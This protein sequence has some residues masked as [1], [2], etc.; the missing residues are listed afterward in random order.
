MT[1]K[2][3]SPSGVIRRNERLCRPTRLNRQ[4]EK[5]I[6][7]NDE[8]LSQGVE[9]SQKGGEAGGPGDERPPSGWCEPFVSRAPSPE[10]REKEFHPVRWARESDA[11]KGCTNLFD[12]RP[13]FASSPSRIGTSTPP[14]P[15]PSKKKP[16]RVQSQHG[17][18]YKL[19]AKR[20]GTL[21]K[22]PYTLHGRLSRQ[23][24]IKKK[25][26]PNPT[27]QK[28]HHPSQ[29]QQF[30]KNKRNQ[31]IV[32]ED[33]YKFSESPKETPAQQKRELEKEAVQKKPK[34]NGKIE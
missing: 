12:S 26:N 34:I 29:A 8:V 14:H 16:R 6:R 10:T 30:Q 24:E 31:V 23:N 19:R 18:E 17:G 22:V 32:V 1:G 3:K 28:D 21:Q 25:M 13:H 33:E 7:L 9:P 20:P 4:F 5:F 2:R 15:T 27:K 11:V